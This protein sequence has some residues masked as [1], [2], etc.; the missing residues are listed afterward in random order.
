MYRAWG[1]GR[2]SPLFR[3]DIEEKILKEIIG[4]LGSLESGNAVGTNPDGNQDD[5]RSLYEHLS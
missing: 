4:T 1:L 3:V 5:K 2:V